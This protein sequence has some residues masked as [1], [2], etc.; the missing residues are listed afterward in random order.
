M[1]K[2]RVYQALENGDFSSIENKNLVN[3]MRLEVI[4]PA[5]SDEFDEILRQN[6]ASLED[7]QSLDVTIQPTANCQLGCG[8]CGQVHSKKDLDQATS[9]KITDRIFSNLQKKGYQ[10]LAVGWFGSEPL[11]AHNEII[12]MSERLLDYCEKHDVAY[13]AS[14]ITNGLSFKPNI[15]LKLLEK[16]VHHYQITL[17]GLGETHDLMR[18]TK[19]GHKTFDIIFKNIVDVTNLP[20]YMESKCGIA[21]RVNVN[22]DSVK[23]I[24]KL[25]DRLAQYDL[26]RK[27][28]TMDFAPVVDWGGN[29]A[30]K[31]SLSAQDF[32]K[33][34]IDWM[35][36]AMK[37]GFRFDQVIPGKT[38]APCMVVKEDAEVY[39]ALGNIYPCYEFPYTPKYETEEYKIGHIDTIEVSR[40]LNATTKNWF[41]DIKTDISP[42]KTCNLF[43]V[44]GGG[45][46][47]QW[48]NKDIAC[49]SFKI[50]IQDRLVMDYL[51]NKEVYFESHL[52]DAVLR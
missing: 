3:L 19:E 31:D 16:K 45:C 52:K 22:K 15:F 6:V 38:S 24:Y 33:A 23:T 42:C 47:K 7:T 30:D 17:D 18:I 39:D 10:R 34:E 1:I 43:P 41:E 46:P 35:L 40:N 44:C 50:N 13:S 36:Y 4:V 9:F 32:A 29:E 28:V 37:K 51:V 21:V 11:M 5:Q 8:Y 14:M 12:R 49:P 25:I 27:R 20:E 48:Y 2:D 26:G